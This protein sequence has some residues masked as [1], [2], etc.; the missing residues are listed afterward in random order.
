MM[1]GIYFLAR[2][3]KKESYL[4]FIWFGELGNGMIDYA[5]FE[6]M[7]IKLNLAPKLESADED[8]EPWS[9]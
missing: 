7:M 8:K 2:P 3:W 5:E 9:K 4:L 1:M 6:A